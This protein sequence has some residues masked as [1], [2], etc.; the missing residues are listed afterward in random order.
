[1]RHLTFD[2]V[3]W[4][5]R[6]SV[7]SPCVTKYPSWISAPTLSH[8]ELIVDVISKLLSTPRNGTYLEEE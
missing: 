1:M 6:T 7:S 5:A 4:S 3:T 2:Q 8:C